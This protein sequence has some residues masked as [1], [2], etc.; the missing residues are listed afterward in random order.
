MG[1]FSS[2][3]LLGVSLGVWG[4]SIG[5]ISKN[6][7]LECPMSLTDAAIKKA[8]P[9]DSF[10]QIV[11]HRALGVA[12]HQADVAQQHAHAQVVRRASGM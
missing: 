3:H 10:F 5:G 12:R 6:Q 2:M 4:Y 1:G 8:K 7:P 9:G 11:L